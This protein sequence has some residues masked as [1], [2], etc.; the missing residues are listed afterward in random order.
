MATYSNEIT[1]RLRRRGI[2]VTF[3]HHGASS[4]EDPQAGLE[5]VGLESM[6]I[7]KPLVVSP[8]RARRRLRERLESHEFDLVHASFWFSTMDFNLPK[9]CRRLGVPIVATFH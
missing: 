4:D 5:S 6:P 7:M 1:E 2:K 9:L 3:F 8:P